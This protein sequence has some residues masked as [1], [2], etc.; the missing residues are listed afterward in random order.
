MRVRTHHSREV[1]DDPSLKVNESTLCGDSLEEKL[2]IHSS[3]E[4]KAKSTKQQQQKNTEGEHMC[5]TSYSS[6][7]FH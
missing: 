1:A 3:L 6:I 4:F 2:D 5:L 7:A